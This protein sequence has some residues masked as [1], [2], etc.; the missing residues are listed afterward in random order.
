[1][2]ESQANEIWI[3]G[4]WEDFDYALSQRNWNLAGQLMQETGDNG[5]ENDALRMHQAI[6][7]AKNEDDEKPYNPD[8]YRPE[9]P[10]E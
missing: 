5:F 8:D 9:Y 6:N 3:E 10:H 2:D 7:R 4:K 1:M